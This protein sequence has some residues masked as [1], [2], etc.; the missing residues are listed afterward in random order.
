M[1]GSTT[2]EE[3]AYLCSALRIQRSVYGSPPVPANLQWPR[4]PIHREDRPRFR[5]RDRRLAA[6]RFLRLDSSNPRTLLGVEIVEKEL[7]LRRG[8]AVLFLKEGVVVLRGV[9]RRVEV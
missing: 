1:N 6:A 2:V 7:V 3:R 5:G 4:K 8:A 9:E